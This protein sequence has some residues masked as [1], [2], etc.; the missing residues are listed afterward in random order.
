MYYHADK[1]NSDYYNM[2]KEEMATLEEF[3]N[4]F[5]F[6]KILKLG[7]MVL[8][9]GLF[10]L[11]SIYLVNYFSTEHKEL[12]VKTEIMEEA[13]PQSIQSII[14]DEKREKIATVSNKD[15][16]LIVEIIMSQMNHKQE[17]SL[18]E[19]LISSQKHKIDRRTLKE[20]NH[21]NKVFV[22][23]TN[24]QTIINQQMRLREELDRLLKASNKVV[25]SYEIEIEKEIN[26]RSNEMRII[27][28]QK[29]DT[30]S[31]IAKKAYGDIESYKKIFIANPEVV[32]NP[33]EIFVGQ[34]L[35][36]PA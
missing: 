16:A 33:N 22:S 28:V 20:T 32:K 34:K 26:V 30:L 7:F 21:Y 6:Q 23:K 29:G 14:T 1:N 11:F 13:L 35:R 4:S 27:V 8:L 3:E 17:T 19:Q 10:S 25:S 2:Y 12:K 5:S 24:K 9:L 36:I 31:K 15:I 18:E